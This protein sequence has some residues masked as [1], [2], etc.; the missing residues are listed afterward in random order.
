LESS[1]SA[2]CTFVASA[3]PVLAKALN[4]PPPVTAK[5]PVPPKLFAD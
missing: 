1:V 4:V 5:T 2:N 3:V